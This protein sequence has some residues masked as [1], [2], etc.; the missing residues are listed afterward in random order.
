MRAWTSPGVPALT[1]AG[2]PV[3]IHDTSSGGL[4]TTE[5]DLSLIHI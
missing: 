5:P 1:V 3:T 4:V 2:P